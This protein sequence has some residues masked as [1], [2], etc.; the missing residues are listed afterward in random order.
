MP[1]IKWMERRFEMTQNT[2]AA[3]YCTFRYRG[4]T[5]KGYS[6]TR[7]LCNLLMT[8][9]LVTALCLTHGTVD[10]G[11]LISQPNNSDVWAAVA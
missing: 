10:L 11:C 1:T 2:I 7:C 4:M 9:A 3:F 8:S 5:G 6:A